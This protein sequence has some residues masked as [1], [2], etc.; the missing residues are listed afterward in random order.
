ME[1]DQ[2]RVPEVAETVWLKVTRAEKLPQE[3]HEFSRIDTCI[4]RRLESR[5]GS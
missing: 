4:K 2:P 5:I 3:I 1:P